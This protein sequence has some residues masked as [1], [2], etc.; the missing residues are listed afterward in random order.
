[1]SK[2]RR[3]R[4]A[5]GVRSDSGKTADQRPDLVLVHSFYANSILLRGLIE[6]LER[7][8]RVHAVDLPGF[9]AHEA[10]LAK[11]SLDGFARHVSGRIR[12]LGL[13]SYLLGGIS[14]GFTVIGRAPLPPGCRGIV[15]V[16]PYL[17]TDS[18]ALGRGRKLIY[19]AVVN[20][21]A[22]SRL[23]G[24]LWRSRALE[25]FAFWWSSYPPE[26]VRLILDHMDGRTFFDT[27]RIILNQSD[28]TRF[29]PLPHVLVLN[30]RDK[31]IRSGY[32]RARFERTVADL[33]LI[34][35][36]LAHYPVEPTC[37]HFEKRFDPEDLSRAREFLESRRPGPRPETG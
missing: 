13:R 36:D 26:R 24:P 2:R 18:L 31:T 3:K 29:H 8:F 28:G 6:F 35:T 11:V 17:G 10:P 23:G 12:A 25:R 22:A 27:A 16:F 34:E 30:P 9:A 32:C 21:V 4:V 15:A 5:V 1:M 7:R 19:R 14:F 33:F 20:L 37:E